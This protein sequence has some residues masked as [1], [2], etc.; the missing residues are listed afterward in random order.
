MFNFLSG[1][2]TGIVSTA[3]TYPL[4]FIRLIKFY[5]GINI[6]VSRTRMAIEVEVH[7]QKSIV[8]AVQTVYRTEGVKAFYHGII[9]SL[10][11]IIPYHGVGFGMYHL[12]KGYLIEN[13]PHWKQSKIFDFLFGAIAGL[14][15]QL[16]K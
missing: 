12:L 4:D 8:Q 6:Y 7:A 5:K 9:P 3:A 15:A 10:T 2:L 1:S 11:G 16:G 13:H 14:G